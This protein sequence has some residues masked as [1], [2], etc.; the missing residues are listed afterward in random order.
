M[1]LL[2]GSR[3]FEALPPHHVHCSTQH[4]LVSPENPFPLHRRG[5]DH[6]LASMPK[7]QDADEKVWSAIRGFGMSTSEPAH[8]ATV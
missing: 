1:A 2:S 4:P 3:R 5:A 8:L 6:A 7:A